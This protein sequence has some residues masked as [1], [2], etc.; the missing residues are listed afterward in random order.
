MS[1]IYN[2]RG[3]GNDRIHR[4]SD[5]TCYGIDL[6]EFSEKVYSTGIH[7]KKEMPKKFKE[8]KRAGGWKFWFGLFFVFFHAILILKNSMN[9]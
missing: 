5:N 6:F 3:K 7:N 2:W 9:L 1:D 8:T 4:W